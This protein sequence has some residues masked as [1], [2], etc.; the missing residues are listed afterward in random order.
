MER[1]GP[2]PPTH[3][4]QGAAEG[5]AA[6]RTEHAERL[7]TIEHAFAEEFVR[8]MGTRDEVMRGAERELA[9]VAIAM[10]ES[11]VREH[12]RVQPDVVAR[13]VEAAIGLFARATRVTIEVAPEDGAALW[14][15]FEGFIASIV[16]PELR[17]TVQAVTA[18]LA[19]RAHMDREAYE[20]ARIAARETPDAFWAEQAKRLDWIK[21]PT[22]I[23][24]VSFRKED[25]RIRWFEDGVLNVSANCLDVHLDKSGHKTAIVFEGE[26][27]D[28]RCLAHVG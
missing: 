2:I 7:A 28:Q 8:W 12:V 26:Q 4:A 18:E 17:A 10:A 19:A 16:H 21:P 3:A 22:T 25:F 15:E 9:G 11:I 14:T 20:A 5:L 13:A 24:D 23:K 27:G 6:A 1:V